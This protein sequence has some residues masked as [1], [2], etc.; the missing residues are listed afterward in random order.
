MTLDLI[1]VAHSPEKTAEMLDGTSWA[2]DFSWAQLQV[3][4]QYFK[5]Y[6]I[7]Q[8]GHLFDE[9]DPAGAMGLIVRGSIAIYKQDK[10]L[11]RLSAGRTYG[12]MSLIDNEPR[13][14]RAI[15]EQDSDLLVIDKAAFRKLAHDN[16]KLGFLLLWKIAYFLSQSLRRTTSQLMDALEQ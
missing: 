9:G 8:G 6:Q 7:A 1:S 3:L 13:S 16:P 4:G 2:K 5:P 15:A 11:A 14:A 12:E 10:L